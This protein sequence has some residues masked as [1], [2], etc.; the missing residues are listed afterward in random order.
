MI[1]KFATVIC[2]VLMSLVGL[3]MKSYGYSSNSASKASIS[4]IAVLFLIGGLLLYFVDKVKL[5]KK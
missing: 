1:G 3:I 4:S 5:R 2:P